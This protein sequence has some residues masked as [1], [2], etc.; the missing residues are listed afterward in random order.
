MLEANQTG[1]RRP[2]RPS[3]LSCSGNSRPQQK[4][5]FRFE[6]AE[7]DL[8]GQ[9]DWA[10]YVLSAS[11]TT[12]QVDLIGDD[13]KVDGELRGTYWGEASRQD[14]PSDISGILESV[15]GKVATLTVKEGSDKPAQSFDSPFLMVEMPTLRAPAGPPTVIGAGKAQLTI[16]WSNEVASEIAS[17]CSIGHFAIRIMCSSN[18]GASWAD[19]E[20]VFRASS[21]AMVRDNRGPLY[22]RSP[23]AHS[24]RHLLR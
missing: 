10:Q 9:S 15:E 19:I 1:L 4:A 22:R 21:S 3:K 13:V 7:T 17:A 16:S 24:T 14:R 23:M 11:D 6:C 12:Q 8:A 2:C 18:D 5:R 20:P